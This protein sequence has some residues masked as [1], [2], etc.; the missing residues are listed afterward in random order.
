[1][2]SLTTQGC[3]QDSHGPTALVW[4]TAL[5]SPWY[6][7]SAKE[8]LHCTAAEL[9]YGTS[10]DLPGEL[11][12]SIGHTDT[13]D[14]TSYVAQLKVSMQLLRGSP[15]RKQPQQKTYASKDIV[16][17][18]HVFVR[19]DTI[20]KP[21]QLPC[22]SPY[23]VLK[24]ADKHYTRLNAGCPEVVHWTTLNQI[25][26]KAILLLTSTHLHRQHPQRNLQSLQ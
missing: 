15:I 1:M 3:T 8:D 16:S 11:F 10:L 7:F 4:K 17:T 14:P 23:C 5:G 21:L 26:S 19:H 13:P 6:S 20:R 18:T 2:V 9:V 24:R 12:N 22:D 25:I